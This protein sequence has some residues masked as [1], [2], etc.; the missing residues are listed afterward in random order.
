M[1][2]ACRLAEYAASVR[3]ED[4]PELVFQEVKRR[5][6]DSFGCAY[7]AYT[8]MAHPGPR[9]VAAART[10]LSSTIRCQSLLMERE[11]LRVLRVENT[12]LRAELAA[13]RPAGEP[14]SEATRPEETGTAARAGEETRDAPES[15]GAPAPPPLRSGGNQEKTGNSRK[16][17]SASRPVRRA[18]RSVPGNLRVGPTQPGAPQAIG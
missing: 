5:A 1:T 15:A 17:Q 8:N 6:L 18:P 2:L 14:P 13:A 12:R 9:G 10:V 16:P 7:G 4:L 11:E 3:Y